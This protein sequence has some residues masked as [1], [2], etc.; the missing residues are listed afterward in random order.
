MFVQLLKNKCVNW[1]SQ[2]RVVALK[3]TCMYKGLKNV[4]VSISVP[5]PK[6]KVSVSDRNFSFTSMSK[7]RT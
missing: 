2:R 4:S 6:S 1:T 7:I 5:D 3:H